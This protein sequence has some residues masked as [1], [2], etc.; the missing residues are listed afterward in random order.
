MEEL[1]AI[2]DVYSLFEG[3]QLF[4]MIG[5]MI[6]AFYPL[7]F[8]TKRVVSPSVNK[9]A[10]LKGENYEEIKKK[11]LQGNLRPPS[12]ARPELDI[13]LGLEAIC[14]KALQNEPSERY[15]TVEEM[16]KEVSAYMNGFAPKAENA[17]FST[18][19]KLLYLRNPAS[20]TT[21]ALLDCSGVPRETSRWPPTAPHAR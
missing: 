15:Q 6:I 17:S 7:L 5:V 8:I 21:S 3:N 13:P 12:L 14:M 11:T 16:I 10:K 1:F 18:Q 9:I 20:R 2:K 4:V 19:L